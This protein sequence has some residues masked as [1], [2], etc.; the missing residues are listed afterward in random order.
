[1]TLIEEFG[2][3]ERELVAFVGAGGKSTLMLRL[4]AE[5]ADRGQRVIMT[6]T[7]KLGP[8]QVTGTVCRSALPVAVN[9]CLALSRQVFI[10]IAEDGR[11][12]TGPL[13]EEV[14]RLFSESTAQFVLV[15]ADGARGRSIKA[16][17]PHEPVI[18]SAATIVVVV[19]RLDAIGRP[20]REAAHRPELVALLTGLGPEQ[21][22]GVQQVVTLLGHPQGGLKGVP[23][24]ARV[25][26]ALTGSEPGERQ[27]AGRLVAQGL[28]I[29]PRIDRIRLIP[30]LR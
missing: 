11:K 5:L 3:G 7:T 25:V 29:E 26:V 27:R 15:E 8:D 4:G 28:G 23:E 30:P 16:P 19:S 22:V 14:D 10:V 2:L 13:P 1:M 12:V 21:A 18:P 17:A 6:T 24:Q 20:L 9:E